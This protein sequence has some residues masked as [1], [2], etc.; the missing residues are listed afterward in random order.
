MT[1][2]FTPA[3]LIEVKFS[4]ISQQPNAF[5]WHGITHWIEQIVQRWEI[6]TDWWAVEGRIWRQYFAV[7]TN[8]KLFCVIYQDK[9]TEKWFVSRLY[10]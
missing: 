7:S 9:E 5:V 1:Q 2:L 4:T 10:D 3:Q 6:D 8:S